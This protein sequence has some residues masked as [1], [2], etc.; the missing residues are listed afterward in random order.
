MFLLNHSFLPL[1][2]PALSKLNGLLK[3]VYPPASSLT[4]CNN[5]FADGN[6]LIDDYGVNIRKWREAG[7]IA[8][9]YQA[10]EQPISDVIN[11]LRKIFNH[12]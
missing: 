1:I 11:P 12:K 10:D 8:I 6:I 4:T 3:I 5:S 7:G 2:L 9:K